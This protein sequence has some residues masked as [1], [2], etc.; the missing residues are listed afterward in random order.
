MGATTEPGGGSGGMAANGADPAATSLARMVLPGLAL[1]FLAQ[2]LLRTLLG[3]TFEPDEAELVLLSQGFHLA[4]GSQP[5]LYEWGQTIFF[6]LFGT[7]TFALIAHKNLWLFGAYAFAYAG[8]RRVAPPGQA[9]VAALSLLFLPNLAWEAQ[10]SNSHTAAMATMVMATAWA[11]LRLD[12][13]RL[14]DWL[15]F[16]LVMGLGGLSKA[17][18]WAAPAALI[19][20]GLI[21]PDW[22]ARLADRR[23]AL[24][25]AVAVAVCAPSYGVMLAHPQVTFSDTWEFAKGGRLL[26]GPAF[27]TGLLRLVAELAAAAALPAL[28]LGVALAIARRRPRLAPGAR[29][30]LLAAA[31]AA[32]LAAVAVI[33][34]NVAF[35]RARW[36]MPVLLLAVPGAT[37]CVLA[38]APRLARGLAV[39]TGVL[40]ILLLAGIADLRL[41]GA[42]SDSLRI[43]VLAEVI[44]AGQDPVPPIAG[45]HYYT[46]NLALVRPDWTYLPPYQT[47]AL[48]GAGEVLLVGIPNRPEALARAIAEHGHTGGF[49]VLSATEATLP[50][51]FEADE[52][53]A[54]GLIRLELLP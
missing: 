9:A 35:V 27:L 11:F 33:L 53:R 49:R 25:V 40:A 3:G 50:Y 32:G 13:G 31:V 39:T 42:G 16:G 34:G 20:A 4:I 54:V 41:R 36:L 38:A 24:A 43:D 14:A 44:A 22:R 17:N 1:Y 7:N 28:I 10:R 37:L 30:L 45:P 23:L 15:I 21:L 19:L 48:A 51:R 29:I 18:Y 6:R 52:T 26:P 8:L 12:R 5:P 47:Q 2:T 46:G